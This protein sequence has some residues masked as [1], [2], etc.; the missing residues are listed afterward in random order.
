MQE[1]IK[2]NKI[3][4]DQIKKSL[5]SHTLR[6]VKIMSVGTSHIGRNNM[7]HDGQEM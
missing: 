1:W 3:L 6:Y 4:I 5:K 7:I 2:T